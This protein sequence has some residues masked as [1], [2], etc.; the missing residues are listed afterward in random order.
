MRIQGDIPE[1]IRNDAGVYSGDLKFYFAVLFYLAQN[2]NHPYH[3]LRH[4]LH[5]MW[6]CYQACIFYGDRIS[7]RDKRNLLIAALFH[8][9]NHSGK[10]GN[11]IENIERAIAA[12]RL[13]ILPEDRLYFEQIEGLIRPTEYPYKIAS[14]ELTL[15][16]KILRDADVSQAFSVAWL[17]QILIGLA[18]EWGKTPIEVLRMQEPFLSNLKF[19]TEWGHAMFPQILF[20][21]KI[22]EIRALLTILEEQEKLLPRS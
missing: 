4:M 11:D 14:E 16:G 8:D 19:H 1:I 5:V 20:T 10:F 2:N 18:K 15:L 9:F 6:L 13:Y 3:N 22:E 12:L 7:H 17:Q 21:Q